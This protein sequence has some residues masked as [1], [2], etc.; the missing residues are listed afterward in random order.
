MLLSSTVNSASFEC[1][2]VVE[3][4]INDA[5]EGDVAVDIDGDGEVIAD[6]V[7]MDGVED[8]KEEEA[9]GLSAAARAA[10]SSCAP[11]ITSTSSA[12]MYGCSTAASLL[13][14]C[15]LSPWYT[16]LLYM[17]RKGLGSPSSE[18]SSTI[19]GIFSRDIAF[20]LR[21][22]LLLVV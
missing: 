22:L 4:N 12:V 16:L 11:S 2:R 17:E 14:D 19:S 9:S 20:A 8:V 13:N 18:S 1:D 3:D 15:L 10:A 21:W 5:A 6:E 7:E